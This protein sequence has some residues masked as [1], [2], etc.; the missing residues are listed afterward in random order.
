MINI[1]SAEY[2]CEIET[3]KKYWGIGPAGERER[4]TERTDYQ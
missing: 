1:K 2:L 4:E 3:G